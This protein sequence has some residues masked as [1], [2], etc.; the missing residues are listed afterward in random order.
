MSRKI[1]DAAASTGEY[2]YRQSGETKKRWQN[3]GAVFET[4]GRLSLKLETVPVG[5]GWS[6]WISFFPPKEQEGQRETASRPDQQ[7]RE[8]VNSGHG[9]TKLVNTGEAF[10]PD[11]E[12]DIPF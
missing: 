12:D 9:Q 4:D 5:P 11:N 10:G 7:Q 2:K 8:P 3:V 1:Y 6:G